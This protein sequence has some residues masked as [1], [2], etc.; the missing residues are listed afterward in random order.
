[1][2]DSIEGLSSTIQGLTREYEVVAQN[3]A[4]MST[5]GYKRTVNSFSRELLTKLSESPDV[6]PEDGTIEAKSSRDFS[7][8]SLVKT[9]RGLDLAIQGKGFFVIETPEGPRYTRNGVFQIQRDG[10]LV[11]PNGRSVAGADGPIMIPETIDEQSIAVS[12]D[13]MLRS[14][15][16]Q[17]GRI[18]VVDFGADEGRLTAQGFNCYSA[19]AD[20]TAA[21]ATKAT[22]HQ[23]FQEA[24]NVRSVEE[25]VNLMV[26]SRMYETTMSV[27][28]KRQDYTRAIMTVANG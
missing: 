17:L 14:G 19:P 6:M 8:G 18:R 26:V 20:L 23:G 4:N 28:R 15:E 3:L 7:Q 9:G 21:Q 25:V 22:V 2:A 10:R 16:T 27:L 12:G 1:M 11:D 5:S 13:G 24:S